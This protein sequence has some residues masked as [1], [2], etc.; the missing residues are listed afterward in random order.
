MAVAVLAGLAVGCGSLG[1]YAAL[2]NG[3]RVTQRHVDGELRAIKGNKVYL[4]AIESRGTSVSGT[5]GGTFDAVFVAR[6]LTRDIYFELVHQEV[7]KRHLSIGGPELA[8]ARRA[9]L[10]GLPNP[11]VFAAFPGSYRDQL[12]R[13]SAETASLEC[14]VTPPDCGEAALRAY[15]G[16]Q[17][18]QFEKACVGHILV[19]DRAKADELA[20]RLA[21]GED[22]AVLATTESQDPGSASRGGDVGC[23]TRDAPLVPEFLTAAFAQPVGVVGPPVQTSFGFHLIKV[24]SRATPP[25]EEARDQVRAKVRETGEDPLTDWLSHA[26]ERAKVK[27]NPRFGT[28]SKAGGAPSVV[29]PQAPSSMSNPGA[30]FPGG[31]VPGGFAPGGAVPG[32]SVPGGAVPGGAVP[33]GAVPGGATGGPSRP[34]VPPSSGSSSEP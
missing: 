6:L 29:P 34:P 8:K 10:A 23:V 21:K 28:F 1:P 32:G 17:S 25:F 24:S 5:G 7:V 16:S 33:G 22:F 15:Y 26:L 12:V 3:R 30:Q 11:G 18:E 14:S 27:L 20:A 2:V 9:V 19:K 13:R 31:A 4:R